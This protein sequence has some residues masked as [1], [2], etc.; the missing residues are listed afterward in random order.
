MNHAWIDA[1]G[2]T[3]TAVFVGSYFFSRPS[4]LRAVQMFGAVL[5]I[6]Y[7][8]LIGA[9][10]VIVANA[11]V[12]SAAAWTVFRAAPPSSPAEHPTRAGG[13]PQI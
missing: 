4:L 8:L 6:T 12:F 1:L 11:L 3:A 5:W 9:S 10:P 13:P 7:G 2:W